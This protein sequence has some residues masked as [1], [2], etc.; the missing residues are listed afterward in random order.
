MKPDPVIVSQWTIWRAPRV[1]V[2][3]MQPRVG[4]FKLQLVV[5][6]KTQ[7]VDM[8]LEVQRMM[9]GNRHFLPVAQHLLLT[10]Q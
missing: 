7:K 10:S 5:R 9:V 8:K 4:T 2:I 6:E 3:L 1:K